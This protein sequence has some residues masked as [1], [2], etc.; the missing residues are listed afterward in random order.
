V[1]SVLAAAILGLHLLFIL[2]IVFGGA[3]TRRRPLL[4][5][6]HL[7]SLVLIG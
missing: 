2:W 1:Y 3:F 7:G 6:L 5:W 4:R